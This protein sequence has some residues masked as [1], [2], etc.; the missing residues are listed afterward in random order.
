MGI[1]PVKLLADVL[2][3]TSYGLYCFEKVFLATVASCV[4]VLLEKGAA[5]SMVEHIVSPVEVARFE[6][7]LL[8]ALFLGQQV[9]DDGQHG[10]GS[11][12]SLELPL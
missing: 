1:C 6:H 4:V 5:L 2:Q 7:G 12:D 9:A 8:L 3:G 10:L 11:L